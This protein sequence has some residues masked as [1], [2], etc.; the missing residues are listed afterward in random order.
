M[1]VSGRAAVI[2]HAG[3]LIDIC[4]LVFLSGAAAGPDDGGGNG[5]DGDDDD[6]GDDGGD[7]D[8]DDDDDDGDHHHRIFR[9]HVPHVNPYTPTSKLRV[10]PDMARVRFESFDFPQR[11][12]N[13]YMARVF[14]SQELHVLAH[15]LTAIASPMLT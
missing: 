2:Y 3:P 4:T 15:D 10:N 6:D 11:R 7:D 5:G 1:L 12:A 14:C 8:D 9:Q 13:P